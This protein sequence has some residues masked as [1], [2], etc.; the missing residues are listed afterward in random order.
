MLRIFKIDTSKEVKGIVLKFKLQPPVRSA[1]AMNS[2]H[3]TLCL[4]INRRSSLALLI[5]FLVT[6]S[7]EIGLTIG[8]VIMLAVSCSYIPKQSADIE[9]QIDSLRT[10]MQNIR[11]ELLATEIE[12]DCKN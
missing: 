1:S 11:D 10:M 12:M 7:N 6:H 3:K 5:L 4:Q 9:K 8:G 2:D